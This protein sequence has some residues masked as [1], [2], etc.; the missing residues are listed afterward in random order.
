MDSTAL[1]D[2]LQANQVIQKKSETREN[3]SSVI[4][5]G[6]GIGSSTRVPYTCTIYI[7]SG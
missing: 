1:M 7:H 3:G 4:A 2:K 5:S 6:P